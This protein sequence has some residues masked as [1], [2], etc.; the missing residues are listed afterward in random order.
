MHHPHL[1]AC[2]GILEEKVHGGVVTRSIVTER[3]TMSLRA[4]LDEHDRWE[5][6][7]DERLKPDDVDLRKYT[8][9]DHISRGLQKLHDM[10]VLHRD[11]KCLNVLLDGEPGECER[12]HHAGRW[13]ICDFGEA[14]IVRTPVLAF[15]PAEPWPT[16]VEPGR[17]KP[18]TSKSLLKQGAQYYCWVHP[19]ETADIVA[20]VPPDVSAEAQRRLREEL[21]SLEW[22]ALKARAAQLGVT[23]ISEYR[24]DVIEAAMTCNNPVF[25]HGA[26]VYSFGKDPSALDGRKI[27]FA[28]TLSSMPSSSSQGDS[29]FP[30]EL[31]PFNVVS[32][33]EL[34]KL[35]PITEHIC[36]DLAN[37]KYTIRQQKETRS[38]WSP[39]VDCLHALYP[40]GVTGHISKPY[41]IGAMTDIS[42]LRMRVP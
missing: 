30:T 14:K 41:P 33:E 35:S 17:F 25:R 15:R 10:S 36:L 6:F 11:I 39:Q 13:K 24:D 12:C 1:V 27:V 3:C 19:G 32:A 28:A 16:Q 8:I 38:R 31:R 40:E 5:H 20:G 29:T 21:E 34:N 23:T 37:S 4:F 7:H 9:L 42:R 22:E 26:L 2:Y 18:V